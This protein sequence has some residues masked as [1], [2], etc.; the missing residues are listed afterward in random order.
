MKVNTG[1]GYMPFIVVA[2]ILS[3]SLVVNLP[4]LAVSPMLGTLKQV[5]PDS[6]QL[7]EQLLTLLPNLLI[8]PCLLLGGRISLSNHKIAIITVALIIYAVS[9]IAYLFARSMM[10]LIVISCCLGVGAGL[11]IPFST[12][13]IADVFTGKYRMRQMGYQSAISNMTLVIATFIVG[14]LSK[15]D[16]HM[17]FLVYLIPLIPLAMTVFLKRIPAADLNDSATNTGAPSAAVAPAGVK[18][19]DGLILSRVWAAIGLYFFVTFSVIILS[20]YAPYVAEKEHLSS[21]FTGTITSVF[22]LFVFLPGFFLSRIIK[23]LKG[24]TMIVCIASIFVGLGIFAAFPT[25]V[26]MMAGAVLMGIGYGTSQPLIYDKA[27]FT[28]TDPRKATLVLSF[29]LAGN[30]L[31]I[32][33]APVVIDFAR[34][35]FHAENVRAFSFIFNCALAGLFLILAIVKRKSFIFSINS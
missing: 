23:A 28:T 15:G 25:A 29:I 12:G 26:G 2:A 1:K 5:F 21:A 32:V 6:T 31:A 3:L 24:A 4:G 19:T 17:P 22:F 20:Y 13:L 35:M 10:A 18:T 11:L 8:I 16:W 34:E 33:V 7:E 14:W 30:Y 9:G 27:T